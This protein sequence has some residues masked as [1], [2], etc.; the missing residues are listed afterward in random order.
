MGTHLSPSLWFCAPGLRFPSG[1]S[2]R[3]HHHYHHH[4]TSHR[5]TIVSIIKV[6]FPGVNES[7]FMHNPTE[8][9]VMR[10]GAAPPALVAGGIFFLPLYCV[11][12]DVTAQRN[13]SSW[14]RPC[15]QFCHLASH[16]T[17]SAPAGERSRCEPQSAQPWKGHHSGGS[18][19]LSCQRGRRTAGSSP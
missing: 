14:E 5:I 2:T 9:R 10:D 8:C 4:I 15:V 13:V 17:S 6:D 11:R 12:V 1:V 16:S 18:S 19:P 7:F 3:H